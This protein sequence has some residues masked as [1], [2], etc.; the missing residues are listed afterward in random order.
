MSD[1]KLDSER[2]GNVEWTV[3]YDDSPSSPREWS[4]ITTIYGW[5]RDYDLHDDDNTLHAWHE[6][7]AHENTA[8]H[9]LLADLHQQNG[10][11]AYHALLDLRDYGSEVHLRLDPALSLAQASGLVVVY[12]KNRSECGT[13]AESIAQCAAEEIETYQDYINGHVYGY[14]VVRYDTCNLGHEHPETLDSCWSIYGYED[15]VQMAKEAAKEYA[16]P[17]QTPAVSRT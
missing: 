8:L 12:E 6:D 15:A 17:V 1:L 7:N 13:P 11:I 9:D 10:P 5:S 4:N 3:Y 16:E 2:I 14:N